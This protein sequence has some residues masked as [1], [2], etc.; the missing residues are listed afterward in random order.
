MLRKI[1]LTAALML[2]LCGSVFSIQETEQ[3]FNVGAQDQ[4][5][6]STVAGDITVTAWDRPGQ[7]LV[8]AKVEGE[9]V[10]PEYEQKDGKVVITERHDGAGGEKSRGSVD[11][12]V[13]VPRGSSVDGKS[14]SGDIRC[15]GVEGR[16]RLTTVSGDVE[17]AAERSVGV[18]AESVSG[19][20][21][22]AVG[23]ELSGALGAKSV[24][25][26]ITLA[27]PDS[28]DATFNAKSVS[29]GIRG[30]RFGEAEDSKEGS[31]VG[32]SV[33]GS[34]GAGRHAVSVQ[35]VSGDIRVK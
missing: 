10:K 20:V 21:S 19:D 25:G 3:T 6:V 2:L 29:G 15:T 30:G 33:T 26:D 34:S 14:V 4:V 18:N 35:T 22:C 13:F 8:K 16:L 31:H 23:A 12:Q 9:N 32:R 17:A 24:S 5:L 28:L 27:L 1:V 7:V 11:F